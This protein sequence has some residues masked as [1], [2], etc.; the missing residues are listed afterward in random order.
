MISDWIRPFRGEPSCPKCGAS[1][2]QVLTEWHHALVI[3]MCDSIFFAT[4]TLSDTPAAI[5]SPH[6][7]HLCRACQRCYFSWCE[8]TADHE[9]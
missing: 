2:D 1:S 5:S 9:I 3:G 8:R 6:T 4:T 7:E